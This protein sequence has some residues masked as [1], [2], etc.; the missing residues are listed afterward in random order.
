MVAIRARFEDE[1]DGTDRLVL[2]IG[3]NQQDPLGLCHTSD[4]I[5]PVCRCFSEIHRREIAHRS[6]SIDGVAQ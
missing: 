4:D 1:L 3:G 2:L 6:T 5:L